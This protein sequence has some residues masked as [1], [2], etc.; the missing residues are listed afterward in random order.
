MPGRDA[1]MAIHDN[2]PALPW[3]PPLPEVVIR[4]NDREDGH[5]TRSTTGISVLAIEAIARGNMRFLRWLGPFGEVTHA[6]SPNEREGWHTVCSVLVPLPETG[7]KVFDHTG[8]GII[9]CPGCCRLLIK[10]NW[11]GA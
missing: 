5:P 8:D 1:E 3:V 4:A 10:R 2:R 9:D 6:A 7:Q 11:R